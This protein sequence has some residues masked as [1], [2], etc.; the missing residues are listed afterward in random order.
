MRV[1]QTTAFPRRG[2]S[3]QVVRY[4]SEGADRAWRTGARGV[5]FARRYPLAAFYGDLPRFDI[6]YKRGQRDGFPRGNDP[7]SRQFAHSRCRRAMKIGV[8]FPD[9]AFYRVDP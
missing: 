1:L 8:A 5:W 4:L 3:A 2:G 9:R 7:I 6:D